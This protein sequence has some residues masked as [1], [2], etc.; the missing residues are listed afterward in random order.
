MIKVYFGHRKDTVCSIDIYFNNIYEKEWFDDEFVQSMLLDLDHSKCTGY[1]SIVNQ[2]LGQIEPEQISGSV[3]TLIVLYKTDAVV[4]L[5]NC[6][7]NCQAWIAKI[8]SLKDIE[9]DISDVKFTFEDCDISGVC[10]ND[11]SKI[12]NYRDWIW[13]MIYFI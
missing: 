3:K 6:R 12:V 4:D 13:R 8:A 2:A 9:V 5:I 1:T 10:L 11:N 7:E